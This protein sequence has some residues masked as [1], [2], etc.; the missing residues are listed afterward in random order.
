MAQ[1]GCASPLHVWEPALGSGI[2]DLPCCECASS[3]AASC[4]HLPWFISHPLPFV[5]LVASLSLA[6]GVGKGNSMAKKELMFRFRQEA[7]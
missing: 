1:Q 3:L 4:C 5:T 7:A 6:Q 2:F